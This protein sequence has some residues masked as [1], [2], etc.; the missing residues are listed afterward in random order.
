MVKVQ[1]FPFPVVNICKSMKFVQRIRV[2]VP[3]QVAE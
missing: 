2:M 3:S 1:Y